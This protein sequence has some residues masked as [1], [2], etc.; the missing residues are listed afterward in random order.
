MVAATSGAFYLLALACPVSM[1]LMM[2]FMGKGM[3]RGGKTREGMT[4]GS[5]RDEQSLADLKAEQARLAEKISALDANTN[6]AKI[7]ETERTP[8]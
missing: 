2:L 8:A 1:G 5:A 3:G 6:H 4:G 7:E